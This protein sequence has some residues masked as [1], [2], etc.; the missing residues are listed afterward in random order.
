M[1][2]YKARIRIAPVVLVPNTQ[3]QSPAF[4][5]PTHSMRILCEAEGGM[6][7]PGPQPRPTRKRWTMEGPW[8]TALVLDQNRNRQVIHYIDL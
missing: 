8:E 6:V 4:G 5:A 2:R 1:S 3:K 7:E